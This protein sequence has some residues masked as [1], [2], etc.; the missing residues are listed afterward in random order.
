MFFLREQLISA[1]KHFFNIFFCTSGTVKLDND[2]I[3]SFA[4][5]GK[6]KNCK[7]KKKKQTLNSNYKF[8]VQIK[9]KVSFSYLPAQEI[10]LLSNKMMQFSK[11]L[12]I[13]YV[14]LIVRKLLFIQ[15]HCR[16]INVFLSLRIA[17]IEKYLEIRNDA[18][19]NRIK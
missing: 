16:N 15:N 5:V 1:T 8:L 13:I 7:R 4:S 11:K 18:E 10:T 14:L 6:N 17:L 3:A 12:C 19:F 2:Q 9:Y